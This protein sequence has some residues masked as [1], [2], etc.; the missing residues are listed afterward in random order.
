MAASLHTLA[1][2]APLYPSV[3]SFS[4]SQSMFSSTSIPLRFILKSY[5]LP[6]AVGN[7]ISK[8]R[9]KDK[10]NVRHKQIGTVVK[11]GNS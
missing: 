2:S 7:G 1:I 6:I 8:H 5:F 3:A 10:G 4:F 11:N 9:V